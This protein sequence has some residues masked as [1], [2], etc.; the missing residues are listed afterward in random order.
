MKNKLALCCVLA[1]LCLG[2][3][4]PAQ[5]L[6][7]QEIQGV[8]ATNNVTVNAALNPAPAPFNLSGTV[9]GIVLSFGYVTAQSAGGVYFG[10]IDPTS[11][12]YQISLPGGTYT[13]SVS[14]MSDQFNF[15]TFTNPFPITIS[16]DTY[17]DINVTFSVVSQ[18]TGTIAGLDPRLPTG[19][20]AFYS[21]PNNLNS[22]AG[23]LQL[24][25]DGTYQ[26]P[27][28]DG[29]YTAYL[30][31]VSDDA[32]QT[33]SAALGTVTISGQ[34]TSMDFSA[35]PLAALSGT[36]FS[37]GSF[38]LPP[39]STIF[40]FE[41]DPLNP[42]SSQLIGSGSG[43]IDGSGAYQLLLP[44]ARVYQLAVSVPLLPADSLQTAGNLTF[45]QLLTVPVNGDAGQDVPLPDIPGTVSISGQVTDFNGVGVGG[46]TVTASTQQVVNLPNSLFNRSTTTNA[47]GTYQLVVFSGTNYDL[48]FTAP[49][50]DL[51]SASGNSKVNTNR[52]QANTKSLLDQ[53]R[54]SRKGA[55][56]P[57]RVSR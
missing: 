38:F 25:P 37:P 40:G 35:P 57:A 43:L 48:V 41:G 2:R 13:L 39:N 47:D 15:A 23:S 36:V 7:N 20:L 42:S 17:Q 54:S 16:G 10:S 31:S 11:N 52:K 26:T 45:L 33:S 53:I 24:A 9:T 3:L 51:S 19:F 55:A 4:L 18:L 34:D 27:L 14:Y 29:T 8:D 1:A 28:S 50:L 22:S 30:T 56:L 44:T 5:T 49:V 46:A 6:S 32:F 21:D 12:A